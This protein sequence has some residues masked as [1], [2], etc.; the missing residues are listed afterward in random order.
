MS[1]SDATPPK[2]PVG[3]TSCEWLDEVES[4]RKQIDELSDLVSTDR[5]FNGTV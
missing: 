1:E 5:R 4:L 2:C 3:E